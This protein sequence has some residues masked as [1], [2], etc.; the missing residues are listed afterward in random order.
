MA[1]RETLREVAMAVAVVRSASGG[2]PRFMRVA[3]VHIA[4]HEAPRGSSDECSRR[5]QGRARNTEAIL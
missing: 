4:I 1:F 5:L 2:I 3:I